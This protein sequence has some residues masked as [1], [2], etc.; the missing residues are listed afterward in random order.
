MFNLRFKL[1][2]LTSLPLVCYAVPRA[3]YMIAHK[4]KYNEQQRFDLANL[5]CRS[6]RRRSR[7]T[8]Y[9]YGKE[10]IPEDTNVIMMGNHQGKY[11]ALGIV[12]A[13]NKPCGVLWEKKQASRFLSRQVVG[14]LDA[15][16]IDLEDIRDAVTSIA[17]VTEQV[18]NG[19]NYLI[20]PEGGYQ[21]DTHNTLQEFKTGCFACVLKSKK[22]ILPVVV[23]D[24]YKSMNSNTL[25]RVYTQIHFLPMIT[26]EIY[27]GMKKNELAEYLKKIIQERLDAI[28][29]GLITEQYEVLR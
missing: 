20:F 27:E 4:D 12:G 13:F 8:T 18:K 17:N 5:I 22:P 26:A 3:N 9:V 7:T 1:L 11:D 21:D 16:P 28:E 23:Y 29:A 19:K 10:N 24:S 6:M 2:I 14:L 15:Q 25:E